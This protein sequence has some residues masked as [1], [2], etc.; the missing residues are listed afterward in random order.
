MQGAG[1]GGR[2]EP[3]LVVSRGARSGISSMVE[4]NIKVGGAKPRESDGGVT[5]RVNG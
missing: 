4:R 3:R 1:G 2:N 5:D